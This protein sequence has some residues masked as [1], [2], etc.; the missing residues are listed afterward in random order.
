MCR[1]NVKIAKSFLSGGFEMNGSENGY[2][3][4][5]FFALISL[6]AVLKIEDLVTGCAICAGGA[7]LAAISLRR[8][9][10]R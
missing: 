10:N 3:G 5:L 8:A 6:G 7:L 2:A 9:L 1:F 4:A